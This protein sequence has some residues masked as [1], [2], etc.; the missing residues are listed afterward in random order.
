MKS[1]NNRLILEFT[2]FNLQRFNSDSVQVATHVDNP[3]LSTDAFNKHQDAIR[4]ATARIND[5]LYNIKGTNTYSRLR[6]N[7]TLEDQDVTNIKILR[8]VKNNSVNY[9]VYLTITIK[10]KEYWGKIENVLGESSKFKSEVFKDQDLYQPKEWII[11]TKGIVKKTIKKWLMPSPGIYKLLND[12]IICYSVD[13]GK[14]LIM[15]KDIEIELV[16][17][18]KDK[19]IIS[20]QN[21]KYNLFDDNYIYFNWWF[22]KIE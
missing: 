7:L 2:E 18:Y 10:E 12:E 4:Q 17:S 15:K 9:T 20:Y 1:R 6:S 21:N 22:K 5:I 16:R 8:I 19:I 3:Q 13:T 14:Q 11:K